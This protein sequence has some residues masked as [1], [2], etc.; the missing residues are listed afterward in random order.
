ME[1]KAKAEFEVEDF[2]RQVIVRSAHV[3]VLVDLWAA[4]CGPCRFLGP[5]V[6]KL[7]READ[8]RWELVKVDTEANPDIAQR[9]GVRGIPDLRLYIDGKEA[10]RMSG[11]LPEPELKRWI[12][13]HLPT[14]GKKQ[15]ARVKGLLDAGRK[16]EAEAI[17]VAVLEQEP[18]LDEARMQLARLLV[19]EEGARTVELLQ[20]HLHLEGAE[21]LNDLARAMQQD[22]LPEGAAKTPV[23]EGLKAL[24]EGDLEHALTA[25]IGSITVDRSYADE[26][27][28]RTCVALFQVL[29]P[30]HALSV[31]FRR[32]F[33]M[34]LY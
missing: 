20:H 30:E 18:D 22:E 25:L 13:G 16:E 6:E 4:W 24:R 28:R 34:A 33:S 26:L 10:A 19:W 31:S 8:G 27:A 9:L 7:A 14:E 2:E 12:E 5:I 3:P 11:A 1:T 21:A 29:G 23:A 32:R 15:L 17:L